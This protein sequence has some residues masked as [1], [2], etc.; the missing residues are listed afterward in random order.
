MHA[1]HM[2]ALCRRDFAEA[3]GLKW[4]KALATWLIIM[5]VCSFETSAT[6]CVI[7]ELQV[8]RVAVHSR[9]LRD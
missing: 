2:K 1:K 6:K 4:T 5:E 8:W 7:E 9:C 3:E